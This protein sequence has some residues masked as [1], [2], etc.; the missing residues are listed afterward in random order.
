[1]RRVTKN[2]RENRTINTVYFND[3][4][5]SRAR[6]GQFVMVWEPGYDE[7]PMS[8]SNYDSKGLCSVTVK[9]WGPGSG[10]M[11]KARRG[12]LIGIRGPYGRPF[13]V[14]KSSALLVGGGTG[15]APLLPLAKAL[16]KEGGRVAVVIGG[17]SKPDLLFEEQMRRAVRRKNLF[18]TTDDGTYGHKGFPTDLAE[19]MIKERR[20][21]R[22]YTCGPEIMMR[23]LYDISVTAGVEFEASLE[24]GMKCGIGICGSCTVG[25]NLLCRDGAVLDA[26]DLKDSL[27][28]FG[29]L[30][31]DQSGR[32][33]KV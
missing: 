29:V 5:S 27:D 7:F 12:D 19:S 22:V 15:L 13:T 33:I 24:R 28:E 20:V 17:R 14:D 6:P 32:Y 9:P 3:E 30:Q 26:K 4:E 1:M 21:G 11:V 2:V 25:K 8:L 16:V 18:I 10:E 31:R 23:K